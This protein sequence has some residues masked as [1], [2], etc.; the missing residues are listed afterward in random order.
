MPQNI[1]C[2]TENQNKSQRK[3][4]EN[5]QFSKEDDVESHQEISPASHTIHQRGS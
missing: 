3:P 4:K 1:N 5:T 2:E